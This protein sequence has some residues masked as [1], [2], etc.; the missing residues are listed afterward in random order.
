MLSVSDVT[1]AYRGLIAISSV[2]IEVE[3]G[4]IVCV[5][6]ANGAGQSTLL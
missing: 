1:T 6:G 4:E 2:S 3:K 5:A